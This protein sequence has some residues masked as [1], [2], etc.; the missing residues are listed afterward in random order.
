MV[1]DSGSIGSVNSDEEMTQQGVA[2]YSTALK[3]GLAKEVIK[4][5]ETIRKIERVQNRNECKLNLIFGNLEEKGDDVDKIRDLVANK[6]ECPDIQI[7]E[8]TR[9]GRKVDGKNRL[10]LIRLNS[11]YDKLQILK[12]GK[13][14]KGTNIFVSEDLTR[15]ERAVRSSLLKEVKL[16][17]EKGHFARIVW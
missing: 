8:V 6:M 16:K 10:L 7:D 13:T 9:I 15:E 17:R 12:K 14:L 4:I 1:D 2:T 5:N 11:L 3:K